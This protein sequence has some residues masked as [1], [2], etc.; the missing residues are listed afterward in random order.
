MATKEVTGV[1]KLLGNSR[2]HQAFQGMRG[3]GTIYSVIEIGDQ[4]L[5]SIYCVDELDN[6]LHRGLEHA[7]EVKLEIAAWPKMKT[8][9]FIAI[10]W[11]P[12][13]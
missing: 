7:G 10:H 12:Y 5:K 13:F 8:Y 9:L 6:Y 2:S 11:C 3:K 1:L 4:T